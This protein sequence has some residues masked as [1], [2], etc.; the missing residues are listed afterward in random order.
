MHGE[1]W[2]DDGD[3]FDPDQHM[4][5]QGST[6]LELEAI[7]VRQKVAVG[8]IVTVPEEMLA[9]TVGIRASQVPSSNLLE[10]VDHVQCLQDG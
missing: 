3:V 9:P 5:M 8:K 2:S 10:H 7:K 6:L 4:Q 1:D